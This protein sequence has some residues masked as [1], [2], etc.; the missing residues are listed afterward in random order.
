MNSAY[1]ISLARTPMGS[2]GGSLASMTATQLGSVAIRAA[3]ARAGLQPEQIQEVYFGNVCAANLGQAPARQAALGAGLLPSTACTT[4]NKVCASGMKSVIFAAQS[5]QL[6]LAD[7]AVA[8]GMESMS[9]IPYYLPNTR[10]GL[11]Y[12][13]G[14]VIDGLHKDGLTDAYGKMAMGVYADRTAAKFNISREAQDEYTVMSYKRATQA[15][16]SGKF[17]SEI[18]SVSIP[19]KK[20]D[21]I[22]VK[23]DEEFR[24]VDYTKIPSLKPVFTPDGTVTAANAST[25][26]DGASALVVASER[27][28]KKYNLTPIA[29]IVSYAD[30]EQEPEWFTTTPTLS[31]PLALQRAGL[32]LNDVDYFEVNEAFAVVAIAFS[33]LLHI[34]P[35]KMNVH[36]GA[37]SLGHPLGSSGSRIIC[38]LQSILEQNNGKL[39]LASICNGGGGASSLL[40]ERL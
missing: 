27:A 25:M 8:G 38:T 9:N 13:N 2:F 40:I 31:A 24:K 1:I 12:G 33:K 26:N 17:A 15:T 22:I 3:V 5:I 11:K 32:R 34:D 29:R 4:V 14:E 39:G 30:A 35:E 16:E 19:Q 28:I 37:V 7:I 36:G 6:G 20:G 23:E 18:V 21:P 10:W